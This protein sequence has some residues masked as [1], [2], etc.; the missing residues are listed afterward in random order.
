[1]IY[2][3][4]R[5]FSVTMSDNPPSIIFS[6]VM[7]CICNW[8]KN[9][10]KNCCCKSFLC[11][12]SVKLQKWGWQ[13]KPASCPHTSPQLLQGYH[14][15]VW[16]T[17]Q[18]LFGKWYLFLV[19]IRWSATSAELYVNALML[20]SQFCWL[21]SP[22]PLGSLLLIIRYVNNSKYLFFQYA[23]TGKIFQDL[24]NYVIQVLLWLIL[25]VW[26]TLL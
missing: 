10:Q 23:F 6:P 13:K 20:L 1:M 16:S 22:I 17:H 18:N 5:M 2:G 9:F 19:P 21:Y 7:V 24:Q 12:I 15:T 4:K 26:R 8:Q 3:L 11:N 14:I 25:T